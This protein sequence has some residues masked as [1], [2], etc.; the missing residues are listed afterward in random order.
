MNLYPAFCTSGVVNESQFPE[1]VHEKVTTVVGFYLIMAGSLALVVTVGWGSAGH[2]I[3]RLLYYPPMGN[4]DKSAPIWFP[5][6]VG[7]VIMLLL[8][9]LM[10]FIF[11]PHSARLQ[12]NH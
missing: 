5:S 9:L 8:Q 2:I 6:V 7:K 4:E 10:V 1:P 12:R 11:K 3:S